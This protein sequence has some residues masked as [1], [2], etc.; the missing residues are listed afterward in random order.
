MSGPLNTLAGKFGIKFEA[1]LRVCKLFKLLNVISFTVQY[2]LPV[3]DIKFKPLSVDSS[4]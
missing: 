3:T 1:K 4:R 2:P